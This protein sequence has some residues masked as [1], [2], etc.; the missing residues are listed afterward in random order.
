MAGHPIIGELTCFKSGHALNNRLVR[1]LLEQPE[2]FEVATFDDGR[3]A[4]VSYA[5]PVPAGA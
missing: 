2:A 3:A 1:T 4:P 5:E